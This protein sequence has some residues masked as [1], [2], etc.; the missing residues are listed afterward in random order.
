L[1][2]VDCAGSD[3]PVCVPVEAV[4]DPTYKFPPCTFTGQPGV[5]APSCIVDAIPNG[6]LLGRGNCANPDDKCA[7]CKNPLTGQPT[8]ACP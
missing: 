3:D 5:C 8:G 2:K 1:P 7:L 6:N 4:T